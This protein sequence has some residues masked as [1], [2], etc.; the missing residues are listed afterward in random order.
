LAPARP[1]A[2]LVAAVL[3]AAVLV[4]AVLVAAVLVEV[5]ADV[6][7]DLRAVG[8]ADDR[9]RRDVLGSVLGVVERDVGAVR[10]RASAVVRVRV[11]AATPW[12]RVAAV[13]AC[14]R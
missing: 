1:L 13:T 5:V 3:V 6:P 11:C 14:P 12:V 2:V 4:A 9:C 10:R 7:C 8:G